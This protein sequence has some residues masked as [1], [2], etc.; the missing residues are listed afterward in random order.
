T[1]AAA[2]SPTDGTGVIGFRNPVTKVSFIADVDCYFQV[3]NQ[4]QFSGEVVLGDL[5][6]GTHIRV[7][8]YD[9]GTP[10]R[11]GDSVRI[12]RRPAENM[13]FDCTRP[14]TTSRPVVDGNLEVH[15]PDT[16]TAV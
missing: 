15:G 10:G 4:A 2:G 6:Q 13:P 8:A 16:A 1:F 5:P 9:G 14:N 3:G 12:T 7:I 11:N